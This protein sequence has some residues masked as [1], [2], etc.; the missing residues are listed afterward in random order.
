MRRSIFALL[1]ALVTAGPAA[2][3][4]PRDLRGP[5]NR[6]VREVVMPAYE[7]L[8]TSAAT[9]AAAWDRA[10]ANH[11]P[12]ALAGLAVGY[13]DV[14][15]AWATIE[16]VRVGPVAHD[17]RA[18]RIEF[19]PDKRNAGAR[20]LAALLAEPTPPTAATVAAASVATPPAYSGTRLSFFGNGSD[21]SMSM[22]TAM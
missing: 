16:F 1:V 9:H 4:A 6:A 22:V 12:R 15:D 11:D 7:R 18:E 19:W 20:G 5:A 10:C 14:A 2:A 3:E 13:R 21:S 8:A 17:F